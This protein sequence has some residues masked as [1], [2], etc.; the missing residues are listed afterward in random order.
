VN[1]GISWSWNSFGL[2]N[3]FGIS[4]SKSSFLNSFVNNGPAIM[5]AG[6]PMI[7][8]QMTVSPIFASKI[9][10]IAVGPGCGG[11][12]PCIVINAVIT[13]SPIYKIGT[14]ALTAIVNTNGINTT[15]PVSK[16]NAIPTTVAVMTEA[17]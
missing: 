10:A 1:P 7:T 14:P 16:N 13:G 8:P 11:T 5:I 9:S 2:Y 17:N 4:T 15:T 3:P 12:S 6:I